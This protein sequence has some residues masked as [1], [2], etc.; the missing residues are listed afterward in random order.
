MAQFP[1]RLMLL[2]TSLTLLYFCAFTIPVKA[3]DDSN[4][5]STVH[6]LGLNPKDPIDGFDLLAKSPELAVP[7][8][9]EE[10][11]PI[12]RGKYLEGKKNADA[13]H[14]FAC[15][16]ALRFLTGRTFS[17]TTNAEL[18]YDEKQ[19]LDFDKEMHDENPSHKLH[20]FWSLDVAQC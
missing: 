11:H 7:L 1:L 3:D 2:V 18:N 4:L 14:V 20:F 10:L 6:R 13:L 15:L 5:T 8:L 9:A 19:F 17:A 12:K 16:R